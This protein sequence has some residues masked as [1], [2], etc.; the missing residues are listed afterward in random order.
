MSRGR[1]KHEDE[2]CIYNE[3]T[4]FELCYSWYEM[5]DMRVKCI[6]IKAGKI[7][8]E[9]ENDQGMKFASTDKHLQ[10]NDLC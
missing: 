3:T 9:E 8:V 7:W 1:E 6:D 5:G 4:S 2:E 10:V